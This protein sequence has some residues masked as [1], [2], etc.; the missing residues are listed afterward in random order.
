MLANCR[1]MIACQLRKLTLLF[2]AYTVTSVALVVVSRIKRMIAAQ[3]VMWV[4]ATKPVM[5]SSVKDTQ[6]MVILGGLLVAGD[7]SLMQR[8]VFSVL[9]QSFTGTLLRENTYRTIMCGF[10]WG[11]INYIFVML[12]VQCFSQIHYNK[13]GS[14]A[15][16]L[17]FCVNT[18]YYKRQSVALPRRTRDFGY[19]L[20]IRRRI[21]HVPQPSVDPP[22]KVTRKYQPSARRPRALAH[23]P[24]R[25]YIRQ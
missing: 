6:R 5:P 14:I 19:S 21:L 9:I 3:L 11:T 7:V 16:F 25:D 13:K 15:S 10:H 1:I 22:G 18:S 4:V 12:H 20:F 24:R 17:Y 8:Q 2:D 23:S